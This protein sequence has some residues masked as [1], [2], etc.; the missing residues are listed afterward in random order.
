MTFVLLGSLS[1]TELTRK[2]FELTRHFFDSPRTRI[3]QA[4]QAL[5]VALQLEGRLS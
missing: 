4:P 5:H 1:F 2:A 3:K